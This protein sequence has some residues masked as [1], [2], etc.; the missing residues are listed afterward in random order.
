M[1]KSI[2][3]N[4]KLKPRSIKTLNQLLD[5]LKNGDRFVLSEVLTLIESNN[6]QQRSRGEQVL[7]NIDLSSKD[8]MRIGIT[9]SPGAGKSTFI[10]ML[11]SHFV[12]RGKKVAVL[13]IDPSS[14]KSQGSI[15]GDKTRMN[16]L[17]IQKN[18]FVRPTA[19]ANMLGGVAQSTKESISLCEA[20]G[21]DIILVESV[22]VGQSETELADLVDMYLLLLLPGGGDG[23]QGIKRGIVELADMMIVNKYDGEYQLLAEQSR[24]DFALSSSL[25][26]HDLSPWRV[27]VALCSSIKDIGFDK[28]INH[29]ESFNSLSKQN[30]FFNQK[31]KEQD[32]KWLSQQIKKLLIYKA[33]QLFNVDL[34]VKEKHE[35]SSIFQ[36]LQKIRS[37][38]DNDF[39]SF[40][41]MKNTIEKN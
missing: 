13:A 25:F 2:N 7:N 14:T 1:A 41:K 26:H 33:N 21:Y 37:E 40:M 12:K 24:K 28:I 31:R 29:I 18:A 8:T 20:A 35:T 3:P 16:S 23:V 19:S 36:I 5:G 10:E 22:G 4:L 34:N 6:P 15:L 17:S 27:P 32:Q 38:I 9:G 39:A 30:S 11:G